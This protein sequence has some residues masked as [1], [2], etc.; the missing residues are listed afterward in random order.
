ME[1]LIYFMAII[2]LSFYLFNPNKTKIMKA[3]DKFSEKDIKNYI[4][5]TYDIKKIYSDFKR[6]VNEW[7]NSYVVSGNYEAEEYY[8]DLVLRD[9]LSITEKLLNA[10]KEWI[11]KEKK[12]KEF[13]KLK[14]ELLLADKSFKKNVKIVNK[15]SKKWWRNTEELIKRGNK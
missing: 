5:H 9:C 1:L 3:L 2:L 11:K 10:S 13:E 8:N 15:S 4:L 6:F 7:S 14:D 12:V